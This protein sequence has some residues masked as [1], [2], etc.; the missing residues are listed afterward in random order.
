VATSP[1]SATRAVIDASAAVRAL[2]DLDPDAQAWLRRPV[3]WPTL[4]YVEV[5]HSLLR[6]C[7]QRVTS[8]GR[9]RDALGALHAMR[10]DAQPLKSLAE[11]AWGV[12]LERN[13]TAYDACYIV[14]A[15]ALDAPLV[16]ADRRLAEATPNAVLLA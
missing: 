15:E 10:A 12:A 1:S 4:I 6:L 16:T 11:T 2:V 14:L 7:R 3:A 9:A 13:L 5:G 8:L